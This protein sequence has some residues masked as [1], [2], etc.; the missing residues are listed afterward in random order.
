MGTVNNSGRESLPSHTWQIYLYL[1]FTAYVLE[2][3]MFACLF[4]WNKQIY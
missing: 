1:T 2:Y 4:E 3:F